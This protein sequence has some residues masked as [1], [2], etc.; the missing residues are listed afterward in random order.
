MRRMVHARGWILSMRGPLGGF[1]GRIRSLGQV[2]LCVLYST[3]GG[4]AEAV[5]DYR[6][7]LSS[8]HIPGAISVPFSE[9]LDPQTKALKSPQ[10]LQQ[11]FVEKGIDPSPMTEKILMC[12]TG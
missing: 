9:L 6:T 3:F 2:R 10:E 4:G 1:G 7:G 5:N 11:L 12:G 8:G